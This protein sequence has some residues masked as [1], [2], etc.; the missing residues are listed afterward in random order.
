[1]DIYL[2]AAWNRQACYIALK[3]EIMVNPLETIPPRFQFDRSE[4]GDQEGKKARVVNRNES[5]VPPLY[6]GVCG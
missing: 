4:F 5:Y 2:M 1:M 3:R 6:V